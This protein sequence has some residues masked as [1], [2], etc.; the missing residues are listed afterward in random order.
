MD[1]RLL[2]LLLCGAPLVTNLSAE[3][4][5]QA[6]DMV[7]YVIHPGDT[8]AALA[9][10]YGMDSMRE[11]LGDRHPNRLR[12][13]VIGSVLSIR[14]SGT[15]QLGR[16]YREN[17]GGLLEIAAYHRVSPWLIAM[18]NKWSHP[19]HPLINAPIIV[20]GGTEPPREFPTGFTSLE[21]SDLLARPGQAIAFRAHT[22]HQLESTAV[23][24][25][26]PMLTF[27]SDHQVVGLAAT[28]AFFEAGEPELTIEVAGSFLWTQPWRFEDGE[29][30]YQQLTLTGAAA[31]I[32]RETIARERAR[33]SDLWSDVTPAPRWDRPFQVPISDFLVVSS[34]YGARRS[35]NGGPY[36]SYHEGVDFSAY[37]GTEV[38]ASAA[39]QVAL[40]EEL[41]VRGGA[42]ILDHGLGVFTGYYHLSE[43]KVELG[44]IV[45]PGQ[46]IG[47]VGTT[48]LS[49]GNHLHWDLLV[50]NTWVDAMAWLEQDLACWI[51]FGLD[52]EC[53]R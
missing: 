9:W 8:W 39:A 17:D 45:S 30:E 33:L 6:P 1:R 37:G 28:G 4:A 46:L 25:E 15:E 23:L 16:L 18:R 22:S 35:Y 31:T 32:D 43:V 12:Q 47:L 13:P 10:R 29:W 2:L 48:G 27:H 11:S 49:T 41:S 52:R 50:N 19:Y 40:A 26:T 53:L 36:S 34:D 21:L 3:A 7:T 5:E 14:V 38:F 24:G 20:P 44:E 42:V 51:L